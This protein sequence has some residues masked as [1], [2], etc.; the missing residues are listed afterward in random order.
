VSTRNRS[1]SSRAAGRP[2]GAAPSHRGRLLVATGLA[3]LVA[4]GGVLYLAQAEPGSDALATG[5]SGVLPPADFPDPGVVHVHGLGVDPA[6]GALYAAT[7]SGLFRLPEDGG[8]PTRVANRYQDTMGFSVVGPGTFL[9][10]GHPDFREDNPP[11]LGLIESTDAGVTWQPL[12]LRGEADFHALHAAHGN[13]YGYESG[14]GAFMVST[15]REDWEIRS[16]LPMR[17]FAVSPA[18]PDTVLATT[19]RGLARSTDGGRTWRAAD[20]PALAVLAWPSINTLYGIG[21]DGAVHAS[22]DGGTTWTERGSAGGAPEAVT[23]SADGGE[24]TLYVAVS[25]RGILQSTDGGRTFT[26]RYDG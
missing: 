16:E 10:S 1:T 19:E 26:T 20:A 18:D 3:A 12:S 24:E 9:G 7:H 13:V 17:D 21:P 4:V 23:V 22:S 11:R 5:S 15:D 8:E 6:D 14:S 2:T 25:E